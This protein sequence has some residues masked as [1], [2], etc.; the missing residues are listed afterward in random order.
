VIHVA[1][2]IAVHAHPLV[3]VTETVPVPAAAVGVWLVGE[4]VK[5]HA[6]LCVTLMV[7]P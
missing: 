6:P 5:A 4:T 2:L 3:V 1:L 7:C